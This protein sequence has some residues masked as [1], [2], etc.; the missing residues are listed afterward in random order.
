[1]AHIGEKRFLVLKPEGRRSF[2]RSS[3]RREDNITIYLKEVVWESVE[4]IYLAH[5]RK[6]GKL[7]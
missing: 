7:F 6:S 5:D 4:W 2:G 1:M 3:R